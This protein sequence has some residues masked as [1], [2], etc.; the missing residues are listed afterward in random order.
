MGTITD[1]EPSCLL[2]QNDTFRQKSCTVIRLF[3]KLFLTKVSF[4]LISVFYNCFR[5][6]LFREIFIAELYKIL[7]E[8]SS[9]FLDT[10]IILF[11]MFFTYTSR[12]LIVPF[13][14]IY[15]RKLARGNGAPR[16]K[17]DLASEEEQEAVFTTDRRE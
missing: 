12:H 4:S 9:K 8:Y 7:F 3:Q 2:V 14:R 5:N 10:F 13:P 16:R 1:N 17:I 15:R 11:D 6:N